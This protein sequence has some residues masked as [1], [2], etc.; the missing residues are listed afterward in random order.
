MGFELSLT[1]SGIT[2]TKNKQVAH[3][4]ATSRTS[5]FLGRQ[6]KSG[7]S[8]RRTVVRYREPNIRVFV[9]LVL[10]AVSPRN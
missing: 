9:A 3:G 8:K 10:L 6:K 5:G 4:E 2:G 1:R 7:K